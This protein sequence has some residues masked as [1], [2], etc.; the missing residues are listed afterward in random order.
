M[1]KK[2][3]L[4]L[5]TMAI[6]ILS[7]SNVFAAEITDFNNKISIN[8]NI[9]E[10][11]MPYASFKKYDVDLNT[12]SWTD[13]M[14]GKGPIFNSQVSVHV[15]NDGNNDGDIEVRMI[16]QKDGKEVHSP[17]IVE[18]GE[19]VEAHVGV[20]YTLQAKA[21]DTAGNYRIRVSSGTFSRKGDN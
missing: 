16:A 17:F 9:E 4:M 11:V 5:A 20:N 8:Q 2:N 15:I 14:S 10:D 19:N 21:V 12:S 18:L 6:C 13:V 7:N 3:K 1:M